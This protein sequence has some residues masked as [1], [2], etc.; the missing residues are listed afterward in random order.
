MDI[1]SNAMLGALSVIHHVNELCY[2][3]CVNLDK[4]ENSI[5]CGNQ[6][7]KCPWGEASCANSRCAPARLL[8]IVL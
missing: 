5:V 1:N 8:K 2:Q 7:T 3:M 6:N 4:N